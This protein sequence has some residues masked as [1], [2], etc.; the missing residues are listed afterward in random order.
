MIAGNILDGVTIENSAD[1]TIPPIVTTP[2]ATTPYTSGTRNVVEGN[3]CYGAVTCDRDGFT[4]PVADYGHGEGC[5]VTGGVVYRGK[6]LPMLAGRYFYAD[7]CTG[8]LRSFVW[9]APNT[10]R[11]HWDWKAAID[12]KFWLQQISS[13]GVDHDG[14]SSR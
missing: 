9:T 13:F 6:A 1:G 3:H 7:Y 8:I 14:I 5:S 4:P 2:P 12:K 11:E 10:I